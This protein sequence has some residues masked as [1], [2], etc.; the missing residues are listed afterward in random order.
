MNLLDSTNR[1]R[2]NHAV[3]HATIHVLSS[4]YPHQ[5]LM[6][7][8][9]LLSGFVIY[10]SLP[11]EEVA[12]AAQEALAR[13]QGGEEQLAVHPWCGTNLAVTGVLAGLAAFATTLG[14]PRS[15]WD[16]LPLALIAATIAAIV[17]RPLA[18]TV[19][20]RVT[21]TPKVQGLQV[22]KV[23]RQGLGEL[24]A[25]KVTLQRG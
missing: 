9:S 15:R 7:R 19:Q 5:Q 4:R 25:H 22:G 2:Q 17:A 23:S 14:R 3:E 10:G 20:E 18:L 11:T 6:G 12:S 24:V 21:T 1:I 13:L 16:R 8:S